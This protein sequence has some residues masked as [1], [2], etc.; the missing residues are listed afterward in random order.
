MLWTAGAASTVDGADVALAYVASGALVAVTEHTP[1]PE[2]MVTVVSVTEHAPVA[3]NVTA[4]DPLP[5]DEPTVNVAPYVCDVAGTP[6]TVSVACCAGPVET[7]RSTAEPA[8]TRVPAVGNWL[9]TLPAVT[10]LLDCGVTVPT[11][12]PAP[13]IA[14]V[15]ADCVVPT[16]FGTVTCAAAC[17]TGMLMPR[18]VICA[19]RAAP[20]VFCVKEKGTT[21]L[22]MVPR[23]SQLWSL[24][25]AKMPVRDC[26]AGST[27]NSASDPAAAGSL[28][29]AGPTKA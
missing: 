21:P 11:T 13:V 29:L 22:A 10:V 15:A 1:V 24:A 6:V 8:L 19:V 28:K 27:C 18:I 17:V 25:G 4:P 12:R 5:P 7:T 20:V 3:A 14:G 16:T 23:V 26:V 2:V 9:I